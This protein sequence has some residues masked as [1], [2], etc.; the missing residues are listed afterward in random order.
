MHRRV[1]TEHFD[2][3]KTSGLWLVVE[4]FYDLQQ[5]LTAKFL[6]SIQQGHIC[7]LNENLSNLTLIVEKQHLNYLLV[8][9]IS[10]HILGAF[11][12]NVEPILNFF[13]SVR[14][15]RICPCLLTYYDFI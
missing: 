11:V 9:S 12:T 10:L 3:P 4:H 1:I 5:I 8:G 2:P 13:M 14:L 7:V 6:H 15:E